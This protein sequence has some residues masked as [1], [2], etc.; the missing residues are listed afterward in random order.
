MAEKVLCVDDDSNI[1]ASFRRLL[2]G[3]F[4][5]ETA[6]S[7]EEALSLI[8]ATGPFAVIV[9][10][11]RMPAMDGIQLL[12]A[13]KALAPQT[14]RI[15]LTGH[16]DLRTAIDAVNEGSIFRFL[17]K[18]CAPDVL[19]R[20]LAAGIDQYRLV[21]AERQLLQ[22]TL[23]GSVRVLTEILS[24]TSPE[25]YSRAY[26]IRRYV[27]LMGKELDVPDLWQFELAAM[28][29]QIGC[30]GLPNVILE[31]VSAHQ[32][33]TE[34]EQRL[35][36][37]YPSTGAKLVAN[38]PRLDLI[39]RMIAGQLKPYEP[40]PSAS[41][42]G[43]GVAALGAHM[44]KAALDVDQMVTNGLSPTSVLSALV[45]REREYNPHVL[46]ALDSI[47][48]AEARAAATGLGPGG[49][50]R[51]VAVRDVVVG[52]IAHADIIAENGQLLVSKGQEVTYPILARLRNYARVVGVVEPIRVRLAS[53]G[54]SGETGDIASAA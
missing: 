52:M 11:L 16:A 5:L 24:M 36:A 1:L 49:E 48:T 18:P 10:D 33:L 21:I 41:D 28:L 14:V 39:S 42:A 2:R 44:L 38:I 27:S 8:E 22:E 20:S 29:S 9:S 23:T 45:R 51:E 32:P 37:T 3:Q 25:G 26:R 53:E 19:G 12:T 46:A 6:Q 30:V 43:H 4:A 31:K 50:I 34:G 35:Y 54:Q 17:V 7:G 13:V 40:P 15:M 47:L